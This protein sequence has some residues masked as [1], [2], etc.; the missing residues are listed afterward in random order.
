MT[1]KERTAILRMLIDMVKADCVIDKNEMDLFARLREKYGLS[2]SIAGVD[3]VTLADAC[4]ALKNN[5]ESTTILSD[6]ND[7]VL[8]DGQCTKQ[9]AL[10]YIALRYALLDDGAEILSVNIPNL[11]VD[12]EQVLYVE[13]KFVAAANK[14]IT[15]NFRLLTAELKQVGLNLVYLPKVAE[16]FQKTDPALMAEVCRFL[17][18]NYDDAAVENL[19][20]YLKGVTTPVFTKEQLYG[21]LGMASLYDANPALLVPIGTS[22]VNSKLIHNFLKI[23]LGKPADIVDRVLA[24]V[25]VFKRLQA[26][27]LVLVSSREEADGQFAYNGYFKQMFDIC[28]LKN[29]ERSSVL[30]DLDAQNVLLPEVCR[31]LDGPIHTKEKAFYVLTLVEMCGGGMCF[32]PPVS[33]EELSDYNRRLELYQRRFAYLYKCL[34]G[35]VGFE[36]DL[37][38]SETRQQMKSRINKYFKQ[39][40]DALYQSTDYL[41][42]LDK[43]GTLSTRF[44]LSIV[45]VK[46]RNGSISN[47]VDSELYKTLLGM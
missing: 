15:D 12:N 43:K 26:D 31:K 28:L 38:V 24:F 40:E 37:S 39:A 35:S 32:R 19:I 30:I 29:T 36:P 20:S 46:D 3:G 2:S 11:S 42:Q 16:H 9:E 17:A 23:E 4:V 6:I 22:F 1:S 27:D 13:S 7:M 18:P 44:D 14:A 33:S 47:L 10:L 8:A 41:L 25:D 5:P 45:K 34:G 21:K